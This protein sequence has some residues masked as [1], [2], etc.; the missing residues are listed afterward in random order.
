MPTSTMCEVCH[1][2]IHFLPSSLSGL[3]VKLPYFIMSDKVTPLG[4]LC[5]S[6]PPSMSEGMFSHTQCS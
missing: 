6:Y 2:P 1:S 5:S 3:M 4:Y